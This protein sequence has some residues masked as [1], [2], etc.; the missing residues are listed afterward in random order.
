MHIAK[1]VGRGDEQH[2]REVEGGLQVVVVKGVVLLGIH[3]LQQRGGGVALHIHAG[4][5]VNLVQHEHRVGVTGLAHVLDDAARHGT[6]VGLAV[7]ADFG[8]VA[9]AA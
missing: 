6:D 1:V 5:F 9:Q 8:L 4:D 7:S 2:A 3:H